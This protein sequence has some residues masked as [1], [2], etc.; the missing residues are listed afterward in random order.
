MNATDTKYTLVPQDNVRVSANNKKIDE[1]SLVLEQKSSKNKKGSKIGKRYIQIIWL[2]TILITMY[3]MRINI[4]VTIVAMTDPNPSNKDVPVYKWPDKSLIL[5]GFLW[6]YFVPQPFAGWASTRF[7]G[8]W[9]LVGA[10][11]ASSILN[12][13]VPICAAYFGSVGVLVVRIFLGISQS[14]LY[15]T[16]NNMLGKWGPVQERSRLGCLIFAGSSL[17][18][19]LSM[20][21]SGY[22]CSTRYGWPIVFYIFSAIGIIV[23]LSYSYIGCNSP[24]QHS[25]ITKLDTPWKDIFTSPSFWALFI[26]ECGNN[27]GHWTLLSQIP[28]YLNHVMK[29]DIKS[30]GE[31]SSLPYLLQWIMAYVYGFLADWVITKK[32]TSIT[33]TRKIMNAIGNYRY[34]LLKSINLFYFRNIAAIFIKIEDVD[35]L[36]FDN[37]P[38]VYNEYLKSSLK[39]KTSIDKSKK[40]NTYIKN[41]LQKKNCKYTSS[42]TDESCELQEVYEDDA[43]YKDKTIQIKSKLFEEIYPTSKSKLR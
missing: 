33:S 41:N 19:V 4:S 25:T 23:A 3:L 15:P 2:S 6:G 43:T 22:L 30:Y 27:F 14:L 10:L 24:A 8:K 13:L 37:S 18:I 35:E 12:A 42:D 16:L 11:V 9:F 36:I 5:S 1:N 20:V 17:G 32:V 31:L 38:R 39:S 7:G 28:S 40:I 29:F 26:A 21:I 34:L